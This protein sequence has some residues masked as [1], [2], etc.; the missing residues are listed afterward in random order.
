VWAIL[1]FWRRR[2]QPA[3]VA[4]IGLRATPTALQQMIELLPDHPRIGVVDEQRELVGVIEV[5]RARKKLSTARTVAD[6][7]VAI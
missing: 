6:L 2:R 7:M 3:P 4:S 1:D 5:A